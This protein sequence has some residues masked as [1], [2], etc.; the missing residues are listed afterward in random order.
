VTEHPWLIALVELSDSF[1]GSIAELARE[2]RAGVV[3]WS[4]EDDP[5]PP[6]GAAVLLVLAGG[7][8]SAALDLLAELPP[9]G[10]PTYLIGAM[11][12]HRLAAAAVGRL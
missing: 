4:P 3:A 8:E 7:A 9:A 1:R 11:P 10:A 5:V 6:S 12:D 2:L